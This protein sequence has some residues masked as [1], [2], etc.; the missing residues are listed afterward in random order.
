[1]PEIQHLE[2]L[3]RVHGKKEVLKDEA[4]Q[5]W[6]EL[7]KK[8]YVLL[9][10]LEKELLLTKDLLYSIVVIAIMILPVMLGILLKISLQM[11]LWMHSLGNNQF[12]IWGGLCAIYLVEFLAGSYLF[13]KV[14]V[15]NGW[16]WFRAFLL[17]KEYDRLKNTEMTIFE[18]EF[19]SRHI[20]GSRP[21]THAPGSTFS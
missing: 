16:R 9:K 11:D 17:K 8:E 15:K 5:S 10:W 19:I 3:Q 12:W 18:N 6:F 20:Y 21:L 1:M 4:R 2:Y 13:D 14:S 7:E